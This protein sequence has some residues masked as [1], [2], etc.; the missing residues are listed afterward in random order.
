MR[1]RDTA[2]TP[3]NHRNLATLSGLSATCQYCV[4]ICE[5]QFH[6]SMQVPSLAGSIR[7]IVSQALLRRRDN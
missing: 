7:L 2:G 5:S 4:G 1:L 3:G 6:F